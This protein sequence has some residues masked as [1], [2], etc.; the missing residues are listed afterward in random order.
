MDPLN[1]LHPPRGSCLDELR[2][3]EILALAPAG[4]MEAMIERI[5]EAADSDG[6]VV[7]ASRATKSYDMASSVRTTHGLLD[8]D[9]IA[10]AS[11]DEAIDDEAIAEDSTDATFGING[12]RKRTMLAQLKSSPSVAAF[13]AL[14]PDCKFALLA[15]TYD[16]GLRHDLNIFYLLNKALRQ[17]RRDPQGFAIWEGFFFFLCQALDALPKYQGTL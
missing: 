6:Q 9:S 15:Y 4:F 2:R 5:L 11:D 10:A 8:S 3:P 13:S 17:R 12:D 7:G 1:I 14:S 16:N